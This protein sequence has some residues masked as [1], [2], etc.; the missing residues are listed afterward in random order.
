[1]IN[2][3]A[4]NVFVFFTYTGRS[5]DDSLWIVRNLPKIT[6]YQM[7]EMICTAEWVQKALKKGEFSRDYIFEK[8][9]RPC[10]FLDDI[11][12]NFCEKIED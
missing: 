1:M 5:F 12:A 2:N 4:Y 11:K 9:S 3:Q 10:E 6:A 7:Q 8:C